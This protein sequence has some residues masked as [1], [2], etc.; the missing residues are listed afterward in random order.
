MA[1]VARTGSIL[2]PSLEIRATRDRD[3]LADFLSTDRLFAAYALCDLDDREFGRTRWGVQQVAA[4]TRILL[5]HEAGAG[6]RHHVALTPLGTNHLLDGSWFRAALAQEQLIRHTPVPSSIVRTAPWF[7]FLETIARAATRGPDVRVPAV[8]VQP[9]AVADVVTLLAAIA[10]APPLNG[11]IEIG[12]PEPF[13]LNAVLERLLGATGDSRRVV[14]DPHAS[15]LGARLEP[16][17]LVAG[18]EAELGEIRFGDWLER[19]RSTPGVAHAACHA[20]SAAGL[21]AFCV[22]DVPPGAVHVMGDIAVFNVGGVL[23]ATQALCTHKRGPL[24]EGALDDTTVTCPLHG[25]RFDV[26]TG[27]VLHG[28]AQRPLRTYP[29]VVDGDVGTVMTEPDMATAV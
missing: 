5:A 6:V 16:R 7:E 10:D 1:S 8:L 11:A 4:A 26:W 21:P 9:V 23:C 18:E 13:Y 12:G 15:Y 14:V 2:R 25:A 17:S 20:R 28:P 27:A 29:V 3:M 24:S 19:V 22:S